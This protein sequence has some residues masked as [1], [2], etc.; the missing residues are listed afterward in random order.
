VSGRASDPT[1][2][3]LSE[4]PAV[5]DERPGTVFADED[6]A[7]YV[8]AAGDELPRRALGGPVQG[9]S[10][11]V[12][13]VCREEEWHTAQREGRQPGGVPWPVEDVRVRSDVTA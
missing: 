12:I 10:S 2:F 3:D 13:W 7:Q 6:P 9:S 1:N 11:T 5:G 4:T 8:N